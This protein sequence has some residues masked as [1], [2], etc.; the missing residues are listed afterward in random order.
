MQRVK[1]KILKA[2]SVYRYFI[3]EYMDIYQVI[4]ILHRLFL[5]T[6]KIHLYFS[7]HIKSFY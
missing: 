2:L 5:V 1:Y 7:S 6:K 3:N 4:K